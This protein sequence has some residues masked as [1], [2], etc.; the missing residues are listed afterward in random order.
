M[1]QH[2]QAEGTAEEETMWE[3]AQRNA[4]AMRREES[5]AIG[6]AEPP[7]PPT[8]ADEVARV[9][10][11]QRAK[12]E[13]DWAVARAARE[14]ATRNIWFGGLICAVGI[15]VTVVSY[16]AAAEGGGRYVV[17]WGAVVF[18]GFRFIRGLVGLL[19]SASAPTSDL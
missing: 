14:A 18:G 2:P 4:T 16:S 1:T 11:D 9:E 15:V 7:P 13:H 8:L 12:V 17:A 3:R 5:R 19:S 6:V 10:A